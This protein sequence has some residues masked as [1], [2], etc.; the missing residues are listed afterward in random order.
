MNRLLAAAAV[1]FVTGPL[2][3]ADPPK[4]FPVAPAVPRITPQ[5]VVPPTIS[6][7][8]LGLPALTTDLVT[9]FAK[10]KPGGDRMSVVHCA[11]AD[12]V[13]TYAKDKPAGERFSV[14]QIAIVQVPHDVAETA[15]LVLDP[16]KPTHQWSLTKREAKLL[17]ALLLADKRCEILSNPQLCL[18]DA[19][20]GFFQVEQNYDV[21]GPLTVT[22][23]KGEKVVKGK[24]TPKSADIALRLTPKIAADAKA[25]TLKAEWQYA[26][27]SGRNVAVPTMKAD[28]TIV[29]TPLTLASFVSLGNGQTAASFDS[30]T[31][32]T[33]VSLESGGTVVLGGMTAHG[34][35]AG[36]QPGEVLA[37][38]QGVIGVGTKK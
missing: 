9:V 1:A 26:G 22:E 10:D 37:I 33:T 16:K 38:V 35:A 17:A 34:K 31:V 5:V 27:P 3:A 4:P 24:I 11:A 28:G 23:E 8:R 19:Q 7:A 36:D 12:L 2:N 25:M 29:D 14:I 20:T 15:G 6:Q 21:L 32:Q 18:A 30:Q 13:A